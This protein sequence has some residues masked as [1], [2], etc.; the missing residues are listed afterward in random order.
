MATIIPRGRVQR[1]GR[2]PETDFQLRFKPH[3]IQ[4]FMFHPVLPGET[5]KNLMM[6]ARIVT[7]PI[8]NGLVGWWAEWMVFY[9]KQTDLA[10]AQKFIDMH[11][12]LNALD[13]ADVAANVKTYHAAGAP[14]LL[15]LALDR[16]VQ[17]YFRN[18]AED[19]G[20]YTI[21]GMPAAAIKTRDWT[22]SL[23]FPAEADPDV[24]IT[25]GVDDEITAGEI[26]SAMRQWEFLRDH[27]LTDKT[28]AEYLKDFGIRGQVVREA[29]NKPEL[30]RDGKLWQYPVNHVEPTTGAPSSAVSWV[31]SGRADKD[32]F[33]NEPGWLVG[34]MVVRP[35]SYKRNIAGRISDFMQNSLSWLPAIMRDDPATSIVQ[36]PDAANGPLG[37]IVDPTS[38]YNVDI[39]DLFMY[40]EQFVNF[41]LTETNANLFDLP[42]PTLQK[43]Y[44]DLDD[45]NALF[46][47]AS[48]ANQIRCDGRIMLSIL[49]AE[50]D[51]T[52]GATNLIGS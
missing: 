41:A 52:R 49:G 51:H 24:A 35:K 30:V 10:D 42:G 13:I 31:L 48:P 34:V 40:G 28:Y 5:L 19:T 9:V 22:D 15:Q 21:D 37:T 33:F 18:E 25:V 4:P 46:A 43:R 26:D 2:Y 14:D 32:R 38:P 29:E 20:T 47:G 36:F 44:P 11:L 17:C 23:G 1:R 6:T 3:Q 27:E 50:Q 16:I 39:R 8:K 12:S 45:V 7:D